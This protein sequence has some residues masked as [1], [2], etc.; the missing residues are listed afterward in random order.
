MIV[1]IYIY[2]NKD[3]YH[4]RTL[5][6]QIRIGLIFV[7]NSVVLIHSPHRIHAT[8]NLKRLGQ[9]FHTHSNNDMPSFST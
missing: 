4:I 5:H 1:Q 2:Q 3:M 9:Y 7:P 6:L 8:L